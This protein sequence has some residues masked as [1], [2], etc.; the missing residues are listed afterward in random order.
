MDLMY[1]LEPTGWSRNWDEEEVEDADV[2]PVA[3]PTFEVRILGFFLLAPRAHKRP[4][5]YQG[6][7]TFAFFF[8]FFFSTAKLLCSAPTGIFQL[9]NALIVLVGIK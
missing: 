1:N 6:S 3:R 8:F 9:S 2:A 7:P 4:N 5:M